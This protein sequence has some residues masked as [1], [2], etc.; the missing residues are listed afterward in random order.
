MRAR[1][2]GWVLQFIIII[3]GWRCVGGSDV[4]RPVEKDSVMRFSFVR[5]SIF[6]KWNLEIISFIVFCCMSD[7]E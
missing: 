2:G 5:L 6:L 1:V 3:F 4:L 7:H